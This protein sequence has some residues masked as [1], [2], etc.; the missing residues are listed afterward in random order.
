ML[1]NIYRG[2]KNNINFV[3]RLVSSLATV[4]VVSKLRKEP[5]YA[6][7]IMLSAK[8]LMAQLAERRF[9]ERPILFVYDLRPCHTRQFVL[10]TCN[11]IFAEKNIA[12][13]S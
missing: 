13:C 4:R 9:S 8:T 1:V 3:Q 7:G 2:S 5:G 10:A 12:G 6:I 11:A